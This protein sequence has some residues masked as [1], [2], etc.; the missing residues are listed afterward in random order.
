[1]RYILSVLLCFAGAHAAT[2]A[3]PLAFE[4]H[5]AQFLLRG[6][7]YTL[8]VDADGACFYWDRESLRMRLAGAVPHAL[9][10]GEDRMPGRVTYLL[11]T[12]RGDTYP[13]YREVRVGSIYR[14]ID[15]VYH[16]NSQRLEYDFELA[17]GAS[18]D[19]IVLAFEGATGI[20]I[21]SAGEL[22]LNAGGR[23][24][25]QPRPQAWQAVSGRR[26]TVVVEYRVL[27]GGRIG[28]RLGPHTAR[29]PLTIDPV[30]VF[31]NLFGGSGGS[32]AAGVALD[33]QGNIYVAGST[34][35][36]NFAT[37]NP[38]QAQLGTPP[39]L[40]SIDGGQAWA[41][42]TIGSAVS[43]SALVAA[44][45]SPS[46][47]Y[48]NTEQ[49]VFESADGGSTWTPAANRGLPLPA[50][51]LAV[52]SGS[53]STLYACNGN[54]VFVSTDGGDDWTL[55]QSGIALAGGETAAQCYGIRADPL[56]P[57]VVYDMAYNPAG[58]YRSADHGQTWTVLNP[59]S[60][61]D[62]IDSMAFLPGMPGAFYAGQMG[63]TLTETLDGGD[64]WQP[65]PVARSVLNNHGLAIDPHDSSIVYAANAGGVER[66]DDHGATWTTVLANPNPSAYYTA[67]LATDS[68]RVYA[69]TTTGLFT[70][71]DSGKTWAMLPLPYAVTPESLY[72]QD[73]LL[74]LGT[75]SGGDVFVTKWD[76]SG[77]QVLYATY[78][79]GAAADAA[80]GLAVDAAGNAYVLG[81]TSSSNFP[82][83]AN[84]FQKTLVGSYDAFVAK[85]SPDGSHLLYST[86]FGGG[87][88]ATGAI[89]VD[90]GGAA[91]LVGRTMGGL[92]V[93]ANAFQPAL[94]DHACSLGFYANSPLTGDAFVA[95]LGADGS[96]VVYASYLGGACGDQGYGIAAAPD[97]SA[98]VVGATFSPD[99]PVTADAL[100]P[101]YGG[102]FGDG[103]LAHV[104][105]A[106][107]LTY[108]TYLGGPDYD[109]INAITLDAAGNLY[110]T[111]SSHGFSQ[112]ASANAFQPTVAGGCVIFGLGPPIFNL[113]GNAFVMVL[114][115]TA[116]A[117][118]GLTYIGSPCSAAGTNIALDPT[119]GIWIAGTPSSVF[120]TVDPLEI[121]SG[122]GFVSKFSGDLTQLLLSTY[123]DAVGGLA[124]KASGQVLL[125][126]TTPAPAQAY[127]SEIDPAPSPIRI[128]NV[129]SASPFPLYAAGGVEQVSPGKVLILT[130]KGIGP[131][132]VT[133][134]IVTN[135]AL[136]TS[137][138][139][140]EVTFS[141]IPAPLLSVSAQQIECIVPYQLTG[142][143][144]TT[145][146]VT[147]A[148]AQSNTVA[149]PVYPKSVEVLVVLNQDFTV[150]SPA[151]PGIAG[152]N[153]T[154][155]L[156]GAGQTMPAT[157]DGEIYTDPLPAPGGPVT[158]DDL[159][160]HLPVT[161]AAAAYGLA[162][163]ILQVNFQ[164][165][166]T[167]PDGVMAV[168]A[169][170]STAYFSLTVR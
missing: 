87:T 110:L 93:S 16:G 134:G 131:D 20:A 153:M 17:P 69:F 47:L 27:A 6:A 29:L 28:F 73:S 125:A 128:D 35:S 59:G 26:R 97:G 167:T 38:L 46:I 65:F 5:G 99:F 25:R 154:L 102:G 98:W 103:F 36:V 90:A 33:G 13:L 78:L 45:G 61:I 68:N 76:P 91:Y 127:L 43:I 117:V 52:D 151:N 161:Y 107:A 149:A 111:G 39:L 152:S 120:P 71:G 42:R 3:L 122:Y 121:Q 54:G 32:T 7:G 83:T 60:N 158:I 141:G 51:D 109:Q 108:S 95:K 126:G 62:S 162:E 144:M 74:L 80:T 92:P 137:A 85:L 124:I 12:S 53:A 118:S 30:V 136:A 64:T 157:V 112:P 2:P 148:G 41:A 8:H 156:T 84:A 70:S 159:G 113:D 66:T 114:N 155:Y 24:I 82:V 34:A 116:T 40:A 150:N 81:T 138:A 37:V 165:P 123:Y 63:G 44:P 56:R 132:T 106:G 9:A 67:L 86:L 170:G 49:G 21:D 101:Q 164:A 14:G 10:A 1:L 58:F 166:P 23:T 88:E 145:V 55:S 96:S 135:G 75:Q 146:Q 18:A 140:V 133:P 169:N 77:K 72:A 115:P 130:G 143:S 4:A 104:S 105:A 11:G 48:A 94:G 147:Y 139:G 31:D 168:Q 57:G 119:G 22:V 142:Q 50:V 79:G 163:G 19:D 100:Q 160:T 89:A 15:L 129:K